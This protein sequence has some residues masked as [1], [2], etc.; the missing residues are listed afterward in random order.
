MRTL[1]FDLSG[2]LVDIGTGT[3][4]AALTAGRF[5]DAVRRAG[6]GSIVCVG[7]MAGIIR[8]RAAS[9][10]EYYAAGVI[11][12]LCPDVFRDEEWFRQALGLVHDPARRGAEILLDSDWWYVDDQADAYLAR[13]G[14]EHVLRAERGRRICVPEPDGDGTDILEW[15]GSIS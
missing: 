12:R 3:S 14:R 5:G 10:P 8:Q 4:K 2:T 13:V 6:F 1:Y 9:R 15:L 11:L 7:T